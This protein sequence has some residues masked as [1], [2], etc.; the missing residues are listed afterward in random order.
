M[1][2]A[3]RRVRVDETRRREHE[4]YM[5][6]MAARQEALTYAIDFLC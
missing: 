4:S 6:T 3:A 2:V 5:A 1:P